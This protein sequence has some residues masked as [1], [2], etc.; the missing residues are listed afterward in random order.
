M[1]I[2][3]SKERKYKQIVAE[4]NDFYQICEHDGELWF[5]YRCFLVCPCSMLNEEPVEAIKK[6]RGLYIKRNNT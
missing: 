3:F 4:A 2:F 6:M 1:S 5:T